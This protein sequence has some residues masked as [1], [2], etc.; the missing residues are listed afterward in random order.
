MNVKTIF[1][2][3]ISGTILISCEKT[4]EP[5]VD[6]QNIPLLSKEIYSANLFSEYTYN[7]ENLLYERKT[8]WS[9]TCYTYDED[10]KLVS[11]DMYD[12]LRM[13]SSDWETAQQALNRTDWVTPEN[14]EINGRGNYY[15][16]KEKLTKIEVTRL[17]GGSKSFTTFEYDKNGRIWRKTFYTN[18]LPGSYIEYIYDVKGNLI[19]ETHNDIVNDNPVVSIKEEYEFDDKN[20]PYIAFKRLLHPGEYTNKNNI[21][22]KTMTLNFDAPGVEKVQVTNSTYEYNNDGYPIMKNNLIHYEYLPPR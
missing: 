20:N 4:K 7:E 9:Y 19:L 6:N 10:N 21:I 13:A 15:Y 22:K 14:T 3:L 11:Y 17:P 18:G 12:D 16:N 2:V 1:Y 5:P 8:K